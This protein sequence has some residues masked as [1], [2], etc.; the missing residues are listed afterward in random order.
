MQKPYYTFATFCLVAACSSDTDPRNVSFDPGSSSDG[1]ESAG[2]NTANTGDTASTGGNADGASSGAPVDEN[3]EEH[4]VAATLA[5]PDM[6]VVLDRSGSMN[7]DG[8]DDNTDRWGGSRDAVVQ[9]TSEFDD[10]VRFGLMTFPG[11]QGGGGGWGGASQCT[12]GNVDVAI[13]IDRGPAI[14]DV[15]EDMNA[16]GRTPTA[17]SLEAAL[18]VVGTATAGPDAAPMRKYVLLVTDGDPNCSDDGGGFGNGVDTVAREETIAAIE[19]LT[20]QGV[21]TYV[22]GYQTAGS[23][24]E[25]Q[26]DLMAAAGG[27]GE[28]KH[29]SVESGTDLTATFTQIAAG[30]ISCSY[31]LDKAVKDASYVLVT[32]DGKQRKLNNAGDGW[33]LSGDKQT[34]TLTGAACDAVKAG[35][36]FA[37]E[38]KCSVVNVI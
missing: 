22:V 14:A 17:A 30:V 36:V 35:A 25:S 21:L 27:T 31:T 6:L 26:L 34:V 33:T 16:S 11:T 20:A 13:D 7:P 29:R 3:C 5:T 9:V 19:A 28:T 37:V 12:P 38:V 4:V 24:F 23:D 10:R 15:L 8:N 2:G 32:V 18:P 1:G